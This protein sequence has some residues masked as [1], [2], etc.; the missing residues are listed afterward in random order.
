VPPEF[1]GAGNALLEVITQGLAKDLERFYPNIKTDL[2]EAGAL[3]NKENLRFLSKTDKFWHDIL[4]EIAL[5]EDYTDSTL[6][7]TSPESF[8]HRNHTSNV[9]HRMNS[10]RRFSDDLLAAARLRRGLG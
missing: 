4:K 1:I 3:L 5:I 6:G 9:F 8:M 7:P 2:V 10:N